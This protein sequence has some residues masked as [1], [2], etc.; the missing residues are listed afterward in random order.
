MG[1][2]L[3][4]GK[5]S[6]AQMGKMVFLAIVASAVTVVPSY[7]GKYAENDLWLSPF[8][9][10]LIGFFTVYIAFA[11]NRLY[12]QQTVIQYSTD[13]IGKVPGKIF[14]LLL[15]FF[16]VHMTGLI[17]VCGKKFPMMNSA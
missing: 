15:L 9:A 2:L 17:G 8:L 11:L 16:Y 5:I 10:S 3:E 1:R 4:Q 6:S 14:G 7:T 13:I 12:P